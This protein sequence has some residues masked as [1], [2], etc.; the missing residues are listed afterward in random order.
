M[1]C[2]TGY[3]GVYH[4]GNHSCLEINALSRQFLTALFSFASN[5][6]SNFAS[7]DSSPGFS[8]LTSNLYSSG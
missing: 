4:S 8:G 7:Q 2:T 3:F 5:M 6:V 1:G